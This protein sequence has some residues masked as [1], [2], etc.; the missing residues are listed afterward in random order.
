VSGP[1]EALEDLAGRVAL[2]VFGEVGGDA[3]AVRIAGHE[4]AVGLAELRAAHAELGR[5]FP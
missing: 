3:L 1:H 2:D 4:V 5:F